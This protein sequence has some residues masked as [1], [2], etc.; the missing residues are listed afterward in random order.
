MT[1]RGGSGTDDDDDLRAAIADGITVVHINTELRLA[2]RRELDSALAKQP[3]EIVPYKL[4]SQVVDPVK[5]VAAARL[6]L[7]SAGRRALPS[8]H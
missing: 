3:N 7:F 8:V 4:L 5:Q 2:W 1:L 6:A